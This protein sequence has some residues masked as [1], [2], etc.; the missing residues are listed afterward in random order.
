[1]AFNVKNVTL[2]ENSGKPYTVYEVEC[3]KGDKR[4]VIERRFTELCELND[5][6]SNMLPGVELSQARSIFD[7][8]YLSKKSLTVEEKRF[9]IERYF[10]DLGKNRAVLGNKYW[11]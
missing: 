2:H 10:N 9:L 5:N 3:V 11:Q 7:P 1:M 4:W 8:K 6:L